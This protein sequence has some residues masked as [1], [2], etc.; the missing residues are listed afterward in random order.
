MGRGSSKAGGTG[1]GAGGSSGGASNIS[2]NIVEQNVSVSAPEQRIYDINTMGAAAMKPTALKYSPTLNELDTAL[3]EAPVGTTLGYK[4]SD[5]VAAGGGTVAY[6]KI[7]D[8]KWRVLTITDGKPNKP[9]IIGG[10]KLVNRVSSDRYNS[11]NTGLT[12]A[13]SEI[14][15]KFRK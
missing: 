4:I 12:K 1:G 2:P 6:E 7:S 9:S 15:K 11:S 14:L 8:S 5:R 3:R 10:I 13:E